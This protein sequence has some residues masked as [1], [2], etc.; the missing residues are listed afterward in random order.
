MFANLSIV[1]N[2]K[3]QIYHLICFISILA[4]ILDIVNNMC[5]KHRALMSISIINYVFQISK[6]IFLLIFYLLDINYYNVK[7]TLWI[8]A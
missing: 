2:S 3:C 7:G 1:G 8:S 5:G 6:L 4:K